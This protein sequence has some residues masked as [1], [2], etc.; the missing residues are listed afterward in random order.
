MRKSGCFFPVQLH[1][2]QNWHGVEFEE[3]CFFL[4]GYGRT[5]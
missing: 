3:K 5:G 4:N 1:G 2:Y